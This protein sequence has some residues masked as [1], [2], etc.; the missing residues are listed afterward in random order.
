MKI[1]TL[2]R[3]YVLFYVRVIPYEVKDTNC[4]TSDNGGNKYRFTTL[5][6]GKDLT[7]LISL[8]CFIKSMVEIEGDL[9]SH[10][11]FLTSIKIWQIFES[12]L[13]SI[14]ERKSLISEE[15]PECYEHFFLL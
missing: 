7:E 3:P 9:V 14:F 6:S 11:G 2:I 10:R 13:Y 8:F 5:Y 4:F 12:F 1:H 15:Y